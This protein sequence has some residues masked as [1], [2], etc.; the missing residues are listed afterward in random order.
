MRLSGSVRLLAPVSFRAAWRCCANP[1]LNKGTA[2]SEAERD[3]LGIRGL[4]PPHVS[5]QGQ[6]VRPRARELPAPAETDLDKYIDLSSL[7]DRNESLFF[8]TLVDHL[9][10][11]TPIVYTPTVGDA[12]RGV[13]PHLPAPAGISSRPRPR[14]A[15]RGCSTTGRADL[16]IIVVTDGQRILGLGDLGANGMGIPIGKLSLYTACAGHPT[17]ALPASDARRGTNNRELLDDPLYLGLPPARGCVK[18]STTSWS[19]N[20][21]PRRREVFPGVVIQFEDFA[22]HNAFRLLERISP[23]VFRRSTTISRERRQSPSRGCSPRCGSRA[24]SSRISRVLFQGAGEAA[25]GIAEIIVAAM[26]VQRPRPQ[27]RARRALLAVR[28]AGPCRPGCSRPRSPSSGR[29]GLYASSRSSIFPAR[30]CPNKATATC[31]R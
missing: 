16:A 18:R 3:A 20:S 21:S 29:F 30:P 13:R 24:A 23:P 25:T 4:L 26:I 2:F 12:C 14:P 19:T 6:Q 11:I 10:E 17:E 28:L 1:V 5:S 15:L 9:D 8:R 27:A 7:Q 31:A 22:N